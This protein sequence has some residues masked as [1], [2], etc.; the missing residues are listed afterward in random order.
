MSGSA[1]IENPIRS[2]KYFRRYRFLERTVAEDI[3]AHG[4]KQPCWPDMSDDQFPL[5]FHAIKGFFANG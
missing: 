2:E 4:S 1:F 5:V 3:A